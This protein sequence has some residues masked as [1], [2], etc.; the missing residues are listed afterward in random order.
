M[1][2]QQ[3]RQLEADGIVQR[4]QDPQAPPKTEYLLA[5]WRRELAPAVEALFKRALLRHDAP[6]GKDAK[7]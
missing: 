5:S 1:L 6:P 3:L 4:I 7:R 2:I